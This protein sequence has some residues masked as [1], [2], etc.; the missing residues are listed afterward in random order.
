MMLNESRYIVISPVKDEEQHI[1]RT[2]LSMAQQS[3]L[4]LNWI[5][6]DDG[7]TDRTRDIVRTYAAKHSWITLVQAE[8]EAVAPPESRII[9]AFNIGYQTIKDANHDFIAKVDCDLD[10]PHHYFEQLMLRF[11]QDRELGIASGVYLERTRGSWTTVKMP[12]YHAAG[13]SKVIR[14]KCFRDIGGFV[15][16][17]GWDTIDEIRAQMMG[18][19][20]CHFDDLQVHHLKKEGSK[21][22]YARTSQ[23]QGEVYYLTGGGIV[24]FAGKCLHRLVCGAPLLW[25]GLALLSGFVRAK[26][27]GRARLVAKSEAQ[28]YRRLLNRRMRDRVLDVCGLRRLQP[29][30]DRQ[31]S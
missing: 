12:V 31:L 14:A 28:F 20:T 17:Y 24:F 11:Q 30:N 21:S 1:E 23:M 22:G 26:V 29:Q 6:V 8:Q 9:R 5:I 7:S 15:P 19:K 18:W 13:A 16:A 27:S 4:P 3:V 10:L 2:I 25:D